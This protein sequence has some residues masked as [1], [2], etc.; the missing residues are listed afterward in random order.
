M[1]LRLDDRRLTAL[2]AFFALLV[3]LWPVAFDLEPTIDDGY[4]YLNIARHLA[5]GDGSTFDKAPYVIVE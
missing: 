1:S 3:A 4:Y 2:L 5:N